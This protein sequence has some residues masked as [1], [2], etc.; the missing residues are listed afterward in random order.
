MKPL[1]IRLS[2]TLPMLLMAYASAEIAYQGAAN[3]TEIV[4]TAACVVFAAEVSFSALAPLYYR[5][6][7]VHAVA[8]GLAG[9]PDA[10]RGW[11]GSWFRL[12]LSLFFTGRA[13]NENGQ[14]VDF[15][16]LDGDQVSMKYKFDKVD[17][18]DEG[19]SNS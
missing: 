5:V 2:G 12:A 1:P 15:E 17:A 11:R 16:Q 6:K 18:K 10:P 13:E 8:H 7:G 3:P 4:W 9:D 19:G 14:R